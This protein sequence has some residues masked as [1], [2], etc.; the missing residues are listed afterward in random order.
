M[1]LYPAVP[2]KALNRK[3]LF[4]SHVYTKKALGLGFPRF[5]RKFEFCGTL[6]FSLGCQIL[7]AENLC[8]LKS[9]LNADIDS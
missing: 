2:L 9:F 6:I 5:L 1:A 7:E 8:T 3:V 4:G